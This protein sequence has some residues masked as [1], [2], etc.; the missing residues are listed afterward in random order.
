MIRIA[1]GE[2]RHMRQDEVPFKGQAIEC[3]INAED[4]AKQL[5]PGALR[6]DALSAKTA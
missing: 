3:R 6:S 2:K 5:A 4:A 1:A